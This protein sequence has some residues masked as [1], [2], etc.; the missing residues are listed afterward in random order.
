MGGAEFHSQGTPNDIAKCL[1]VSVTL[2]KRSG[3]F[4]SCVYMML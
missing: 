2:L 4:A 3:N 1:E